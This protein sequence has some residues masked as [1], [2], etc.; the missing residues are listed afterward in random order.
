MKYNFHLNVFEETEIQ[1]DK[2]VISGSDCDISWIE[3]QQKVERLKIIFSE[4]NIPK[5]HPVII[6]GHKEHFFPVAM[7]ALINSGIPY[8]PIDKIYPTERIKKIIDKTGSQILINC[9]DYKIP[10]AVSVEIDFQLNIKRNSDADFTNII[11]GDCNDPLQYIMFT[12]GSTGE[13][14]GVQINR[15]SILSFLD[16]IEKDYWFNK[17]D[18]FMNQSPFTFDVSLYD[19]LSAFMLGA[20]V[21]LIDNDIAKDAE[22]LFVKLQQYNCTVW[23]STPS[24]A[25]IYLREKKFNSESLNRI[26]TFLFAGEDLPPRTVEI[27]LMNFPQAKVYNA[28]GPTEA[29]VTTTLIEINADILKKYPVLPIGYPKRNTEI[30]IDKQN[31]TDKSGEIIIVG[32]HVSSGYFKEEE[33]SAEKFYLHNRHR[34]F[35]T[36]D[37]GYYENEMIFFIGRN[38]D[39]IKLHGYRIELSEITSVIRKLDFIEDAVTVPLKKDKEVKRIVSFVILKNGMSSM[40]LKEKIIKIIDGQLPPYMIPGDI[41]EVKTFPISSNHK[42]DKNKLIALY[43]DG[44]LS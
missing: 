16:W 9:G 39:Q 8:I 37:L 29:T 7:L 28:Y 26:H 33:L 20:T 27:L 4:L 32:D 15:S 18:V 41:K 11:Y 3:L 42:I 38:D 23:T 30:L 43:K 36:G 2:I 24:F 6:Y 22:R 5:G 34:A 40:A 19:T 14:K 17:D 1:P 13:P 21:L 35:R 44:L 25:Y 31:Q 10:V 12:S